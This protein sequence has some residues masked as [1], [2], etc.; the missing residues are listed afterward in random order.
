MLYYKLFVD[1]NQK[2]FDPFVGR[3]DGSHLQPQSK[4]HSRPAVVLCLQMG[5][6][7]FRICYVIYLLMYIEAI[8]SQNI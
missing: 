5:M 7:C 2:A 1:F 3:F 8:T 4:P 6:F